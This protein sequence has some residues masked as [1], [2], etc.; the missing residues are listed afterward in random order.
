[1]ALSFSSNQMA[2]TTAPQTVSLVPASLLGFILLTAYTMLSLEMHTLL[3]LQILKT[4]LLISPSLTSFASLL[5]LPTLASCTMVKPSQKTDVIFN[6]F[7][8]LNA[9]NATLNILFNFCPPTPHSQKDWW[10]L[11]L[12]SFCSS[13]SWCCCQWFS[14]IQIWLFLCFKTLN[15]FLL[16]MEWSPNS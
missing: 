8:S 6:S 7:Y 14:K 11:H 2:S 9:S 5:R 12:T 3:K 4:Q 15:G 16:L 13:P 10:L 1:M